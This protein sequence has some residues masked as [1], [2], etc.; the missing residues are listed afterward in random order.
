MQEAYPNCPKYITRRQLKTV[1]TELTESVA[2]TTGATLYGAATGRFFE[3]MPSKRAQTS[4]NIELQP[5]REPE[6]PGVFCVLAS[7]GPQCNHATEGWFRSFSLQV[8]ENQS[9]KMRLEDVRALR[10]SRARTGFRQLSGPFKPRGR[11]GISL[12]AASSAHVLR[13]QF[14]VRLAEPAQFRRVCEILVKLERLFRFGRAC[15]AKGCFNGH[16]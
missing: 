8:R 1:S 15:V 3:T 12:K 11:R 6:S 10:A 5:R 2:D 9:G 13:I 14:V 16:S 4:R 7:G